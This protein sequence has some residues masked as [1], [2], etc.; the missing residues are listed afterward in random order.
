M[1]QEQAGGLVEL[2]EQEVKKVNG[3]SALAI[4]GPAVVGAVAGIAANEAVERKTGKD[5][6][7]H[8]GNALE[9]AGES[10]EDWGESLTN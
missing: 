4:G 8:A 1:N 3:G 2:S 7:T 10:L 9:D 5:I 6:P